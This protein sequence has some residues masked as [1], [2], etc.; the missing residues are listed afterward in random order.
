[1]L[2]PD[3]VTAP[4]SEAG[5]SLSAIASQDTREFIRYFAAS[6][7]ALVVDFGILTYLTGV[8]NIDY[9]ISGA[10]AF[11]LG[12]AIVYTLS[13]LWVFDRR[14]VRTP[15][16]EFI[17]FAAIGIAGLFLNEVV[18]WLFTGVFGMFYL[19]SKCLSVVLVFMWNYIARKFLLFR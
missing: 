5:I 2:D 3:I 7:V 15:F 17:I 6:L 11:F 8:L 13:V 18:L 12:L 1:M 14:S 16:V 19:I 9:L 10:I 4:E